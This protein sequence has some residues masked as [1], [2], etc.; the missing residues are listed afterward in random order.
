MTERSYD[1]HSILGLSG[2][3]YR[4]HYLAYVM[5]FESRTVLQISIYSEFQRIAPIT[6]PYLP[7]P[8][9]RVKYHVFLYVANVE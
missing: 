2:D 9:P 4:R 7:Q 8:Q 1:K 5:K 3:I 6:T